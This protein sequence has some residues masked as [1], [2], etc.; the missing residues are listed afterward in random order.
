MQHDSQAV[1]IQCHSA[2]RAAQLRFIVLGLLQAEPPFDQWGLLP[3]EPSDQDPRS[4]NVQIPHFE[5]HY[6]NTLRQLPGVQEVGIFKSSRP[7]PDPWQER[8]GILRTRD[9]ESIEDEFH[10]IAA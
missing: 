3:V 4:V 7:L 1:Y 10:R 9:R 8:C 2:Q 6:L 5:E